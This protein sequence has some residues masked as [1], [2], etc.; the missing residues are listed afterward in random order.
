MTT[1]LTKALQLGRQR[2][3]RN[4]VR[5]I[6]VKSELA[7]GAHLPA[8]SSRA[9]FNRSVSELSHLQ[10]NEE[11]V[12]DV[13][14]TTERYRGYGPYRSIRPMQIRSEHRALLDLVRDHDPTT[15][16][17]IGTARG[18]TLY[19][20]CRAVDSAETI[21]SLDL[22]AGEFGGGYSHQRIDLFEAFETD[23]ELVFVR[24]D[25][26]DSETHASVKDAIDGRLDLLFIDG[27]HTYDGVKQDF[28]MYREF[29]A[30]GA[31]VAFHD[32][33]PH[34]Y[35]SECEVDQFWTEIKEDF[36]SWEFVLDPDQGWAGIGVVEV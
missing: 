29:A 21:I 19:G 34:E 1:P 15:L 3:Y 10:A 18:G 24:G 27:D 11:T 6:E 7:L 17:E 28:E 16:L 14:D 33:I 20:W 32:I 5:R 31:L 36:P 13:L 35:D 12:A 30:D 22:P 9:C 4:L 26:H 2:G 25:S 23:A 8:V